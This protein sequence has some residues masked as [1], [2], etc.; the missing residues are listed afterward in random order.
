MET[1][2]SLYCKFYKPSLQKNLR[3]KI[4]KNHKKLSKKLC[5]KDRRKLLEIIDNESLI[6]NIHS[7]ESFICGLK[8]GLSIS[9]EL[10]SSEQTDWSVN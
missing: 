2:E 8:L 9:S 1:L 3:E 10:L 6:G 5:R 4:D 7:H